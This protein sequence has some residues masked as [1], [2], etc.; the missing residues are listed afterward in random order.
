[1]TDQIKNENLFYDAFIEEETAILQA[2]FS[3]TDKNVFA[4]ITPK[5]VDRGALMSRYSRTDKTMRRVF[6][7]EF[8]RNPK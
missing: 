8:I 5:Q 4:I 6:L 3:N 7:D 2:H 1:L